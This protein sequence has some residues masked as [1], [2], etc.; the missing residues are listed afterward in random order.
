MPKLYLSLLLSMLIWSPALAGDEDGEPTDETD[1]SAGEADGDQAPAAEDEAVEAEATPEAE[2]EADTEAEEPVADEPVT[3]E[4]VT[5]E[6]VADEPVAD[7]PVAPPAAP[8]P[9]AV[10]E[11]PAVP[12]AAVSGDLTPEELA[13]LRELL[14]RIEGD[15]DEWK[16]PAPEPKPARHRFSDFVKTTL[17]FYIGDDNL[18][19]GNEDRSPNLGMANEYPELFFEGLNSEK[20]AVVSETHM[21]LYGQTPGYLPFIDT[22]A[23]FVAEFELAR[24]PE[25]NH[26]LVSRFKDDGSYIG[27]TVY[28]KRD[29][30][31]PSLNLTAWPYSANRFRLGYTYDLTWGGNTIWAGNR[32]PVP[33]AKITLDLERFYFFVGAKAMVQIRADNTE[34]ENYWGVLAGLGPNFTFGPDLKFTYDAGAGYFTR[35]TF[36]QAPFRSIPLQAYGISQRVQLTL[37]TRM[38][39]SPD[40]KPLSN[41]P[42]DFWVSRAIVPEYDGVWGFGVGAEFTTVWQTL[43]DADAPSTRVADNAITFGGFAQARFAKSMR[44]GL[45]VVYRDVDFL[46]FNVP[47][48]APYLSF[49]EGTIQKPQVY[50]AIWWDYYIEKAHLTPTV[51]FGL[52][53][54]ASFQ[55]L[56]NDSGNRQMAIIREAN[57]YELMPE[58]LDRAY[59]ILSGKVSL[60]WH[61]SSILAITGE[62]SYTHDYNVS[63]VVTNDETGVG[64]RV[65]DDAMA[66]RLGLNL[67]VQAAF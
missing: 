22:E 33:G 61:V 2:G 53:Q 49:A 48:Y 31:G 46:V 23:A 36:Q 25:R 43:I 55:S 17:T 34:A 38:G 62:V 12:E 16:G 66:R 64:E 1:D 9:P 27:L 41:R 13:T 30:T 45:D 67:I 37:R 63:K 44:V 40:L 42:D 65:L 10:P 47:G 51:I 7:E 6:P 8:E 26:E 19:A 57:D 21:V 3:D 20:Q 56:A 54:P 39:L 32:S 28:F 4:P 11:V 24:D 18:L 52:M 14:D 60:K 15:D 5:D 50:G 58:G 29:K 35:G 59:T